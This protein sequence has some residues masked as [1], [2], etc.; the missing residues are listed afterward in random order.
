MTATAFTATSYQCHAF[1]DSL[2]D[3]RAAGELSLSPLGLTY[4]VASLLGTLPFA[5]LEFTLGGSA[6]SLVFIKHPHKPDLTLY[7]SDLSI[8]RNPA[9]LAHPECSH[10]INK[11][12]RKR[13]GGWASLAAFALFLLAL[14]AIF[15]WQIDHL[16]I[17]AARQIPVTWE[18][19][20]GASVDARQKLENTNMPQAEADALLKP[21]TT[22]LLQAIPKS[23]YRYQIS[24]INNKSSNAFAL[25]GGYVTIHSGLILKA[26]SAEELLGVLAHEISHVEE[27]HGTRAIIGNAG[28]YLVASAV[29]GDVTG[30]L[31]TVSNAAPLLLS[32]QHSRHFETDA[33]EKAVSLLKRAHIDPAGLPRFFERMIAEEKAMLEKIDNAQARAA[34]QSAMSLLST[35]PA[36]EKRM[37]HLRKLIGKP[38]ADYL[39]QEAEFKNLQ[40]AVKKFVSK[41]TETPK[42]PKSTSADESQS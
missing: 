42:A 12:R 22:P 3:G 24:I 41:T 25:P 30:L 33:D 40:E 20:L 13:M 28:I 16:S 29:L 34:Y 31:A 37:T 5:Q 2:A 21:L 14:P 11:A 38:E 19:Q 15:L 7:T 6:N 23:P 10:Q 4:K 26:G 17:Y 35:H 36:S 8:L 39:N 9:L 1:H 18:Q 32:Q 27:R